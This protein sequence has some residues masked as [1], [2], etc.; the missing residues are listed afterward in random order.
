M[1]NSFSRIIISYF[2]K[3]ELNTNPAMLTVDVADPIL[4][5]SLPYLHKPNG[6]PDLFDKIRGFTIDV[7]LKDHHICLNESLRMWEWVEK[8]QLLSGGVFL[9]TTGY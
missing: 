8:A 9:D 4:I 5:L 1:I 2:G 3:N 7:I 6:D